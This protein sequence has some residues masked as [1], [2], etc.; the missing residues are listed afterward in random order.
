MNTFWA[1]DRA[2]RRHKPEPNQQALRWPAGRAGP[3]GEPMMK[4][5]VNGALAA[6]LLAGTAGIAAAQTAVI[7]L[8]PDQRT[9]VYRSI[10]RERIEVA[11]PADFRARVG[12]EVP[13]AVELYPV[14]E[15]IEVPA[16]RRY[17]Y[18]VVDDQV[19]LV[20]PSTHR[21]VEIIG[22]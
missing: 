22:E 11:P 14:P 4:F 7:E 12:V 16:I 5:F 17:R 2:L 13:A 3:K 9:T 8:S 21:I 18:T 6:I 20:D 1:A 19:V 15:A 10:T